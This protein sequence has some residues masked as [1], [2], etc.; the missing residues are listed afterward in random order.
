MALSK[1]P[2]PLE[3][4]EQ[5][6]IFCNQTA[7]L[8]WLVSREH[9]IDDSHMEE[10]MR[11]LKTDPPSLRDEI[12]EMTHTQRMAKLMR[13]LSTPDYAVCVARTMITQVERELAEAERALECARMIENNGQPQ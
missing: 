7:I 4:D 6:A 13:S 12:A 1:W 10:S 9:A 3:P 8:E 11:R 5:A 2:I